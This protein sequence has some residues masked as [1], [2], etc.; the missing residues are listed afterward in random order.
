VKLYTVTAYG[1]KEWL[2]RTGRI[3]G[4]LVYTQVVPYFAMAEIKSA[5]AAHFNIP[6]IEM[7]SARRCREY[8]RP[9]QVSMYLCKQLTPKSLP[10]IG[11]A[12][13]DRDHTTVIH[14][15]RRVQELRR[16]DPEIEH[17]IVALTEKLSRPNTPE[18]GL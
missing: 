4:D 2:C 15:N 6:L 14:A 3:P 10:E 5:V 13:G 18:G 8:A 1:C 17:A 16:A 11:R 12:H 9:R 7:T